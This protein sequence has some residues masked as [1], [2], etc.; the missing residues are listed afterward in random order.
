[1]NIHSGKAAIAFL[2]GESSSDD[3][4]VVCPSCGSDYTHVRHVGTLVGSDQFEAVVAYDGASPSGATPQRRSAVEIVFSCE[5]C[6]KLFSSST[7]ESR[8]SSN[9]HML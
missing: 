5:N 3:A 6:P 9:C 7:V 8:K 2:S 4:N 1:M